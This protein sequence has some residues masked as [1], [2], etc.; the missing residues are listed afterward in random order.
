MPTSPTF[1][2]Y[3][4]TNAQTLANDPLYSRV[5]NE[6]RHPPLQLTTSCPHCQAWRTCI[7]VREREIE[8]AD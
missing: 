5:V 6:L 7:C 8:P 1:G 2:R 3:S 4:R